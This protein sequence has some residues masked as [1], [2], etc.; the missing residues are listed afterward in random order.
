MAKDVHNALVNVLKQHGQ[1]NSEQ[2]EEYLS[3]LRSNKRYQKDV[4]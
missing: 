2:A 3:T 4:Y 1:L